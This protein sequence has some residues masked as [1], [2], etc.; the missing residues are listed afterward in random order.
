MTLVLDS[1]TTRS[2]CPFPSKAPSI[3]EWVEPYYQFE[4]SDSPLLILYKIQEI[5]AK[6]EGCEAQTK[7]DYN[8]YKLRV[9]ACINGTILKFNVNVY[10]NSPVDFRFSQSHL[11]EFQRRCG[12][13]IVFGTCFRQIQE[14][15]GLRV[16]EDVLTTDLVLN[17][18]HL[19]ELKSTVNILHMMMSVSALESLTAL[20][21][22]LGDVSQVNRALLCP[23]EPQILALLSQPK[24]DVRYLLLTLLLA[25]GYIPT[26][27]TQKLLQQLDLGT[28]EKVAGKA[29]ALLRLA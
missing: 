15:L 13:A 24:I 9:D 20:I 16:R 17:G 1:E 28:S 27:T 26:R 4:T 23:T 19:E 22:M 7:L 10:T 25:C 5:I 12:C 6:L 21:V 11:V 2:A 29:R 8:A 3:P 18:V 14:H